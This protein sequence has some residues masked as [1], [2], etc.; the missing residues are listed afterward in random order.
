MSAIKVKLL[1]ATAAL[2]LLPASASA[3]ATLPPELQ[4]I[5]QSETASTKDAAQAKA[6]AEPPVGIEID[7]TSVKQLRDMAERQTRIKMLRLEL[8]EKELQAEIDALAAEKEDANAE[9][10]EPPVRDPRNYPQYWQQQPQQPG[11]MGP[12]SQMPPGFNPRPSDDLSKL[13]NLVSIGGAGGDL[14]ARANLNGGLVLLREGDRLPGGF[15]VH[16]VSRNA[17]TVKSDVTEDTYLLTANGAERTDGA[18]PQSRGAMF[19]PMGQ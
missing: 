2:A 19:R 16:E 7:P 12:R 9:P 1:A 18:D 14:V 6:K 15:V 8:T 17:V 13:P 5:S 3:E 11:A 4:Q 10:A